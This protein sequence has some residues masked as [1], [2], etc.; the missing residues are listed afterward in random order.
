MDVHERGVLV[1]VRESCA[2]RPE[3]RGLWGVVKDWEG[4]EE[5]AREQVL[6]RLQNR[7]DARELG[8]REAW[9]PA[10]GLR[11]VRDARALRHSHSRT[12]RA[13]YDLWRRTTRDAAFMH[14]PLEA[15]HLRAQREAARAEQAQEQQRRRQQEEEDTRARQEQARRE[16]ERKEKEEEE[17]GERARKRRRG[18]GDEDEAWTAP[19]LVVRVASDAVVYGR[20]SLRGRTAAVLDVVSAAGACTLHVLPTAA[21]ARAGITVDA[22]AAAALAPVRPPPGAPARILRGPHRGAT[23]EVIVLP[24]SSSELSLSPPESVVAVQLQD[25]SDEVVL[26][27]PADVCLCSSAGAL[28]QQLPLSSA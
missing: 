12:A 9:L 3:F 20:Q 10:A 27:A 15:D 8:A 18:D 16:R 14:A 23:G 25:G 28:Q 4:A 22:V 17:E 24:E 2:A 11:A 7:A 26:C 6:V 21:D 1:Q 13:A 5:G 19:G